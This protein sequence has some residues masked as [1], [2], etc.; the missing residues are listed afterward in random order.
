M[1]CIHLIETLKVKQQGKDC[2]HLIYR[3]EYLLPPLQLA[4]L[5]TN[6]Q[7][8][9]VFKEIKDTVDAL[10]K[11]DKTVQV[12]SSIG[13]KKLHNIAFFNHLKNSGYK[14][15]GIKEKGG[16]WLWAS[17]H[18]KDE[19]ISLLLIDIHPLGSE[20]EKVDPFLFA[21][22]YIMSNIIVWNVENDGFDAMKDIITRSLSGIRQNLEVVKSHENTKLPNITLEAPK[23]V[24]LS[25][26]SKH[27]SGLLG[28]GSN[29][30]LG[31][32]H[33][34][35]ESFL[36]KEKPNSILTSFIKVFSDPVFYRI[37]EENLDP[38]GYDKHLKE[39]EELLL[40]HFIGHKT[41]WGMDMTIGR[42]LEIFKTFVQVP[43][44]TEVIFSGRGA[45]WGG[46]R[47]GGGV[48]DPEVGN[49]MACVKQTF[50]EEIKK[51]ALRGFKK[52]IDQ[53]S[54]FKDIIKVS[55]YDTIMSVNQIISDTSE[56]ALSCTNFE[57][58]QHI[59]NYIHYCLKQA[60]GDKII[61]QL[62][63]L[64]DAQL[65][66][67]HDPAN[68]LCELGFPPVS[69]ITKKHPRS[70]V[71]ALE[72]ILTLF[73]TT[74]D[75]GAP[76]PMV[77]LTSLGASSVIKNNT[78]IKEMDNKKNT[79][80][81]QH[82]FPRF[83]QSAN[84]F[85]EFLFDESISVWIGEG[86]EDPTR[87]IAI[88]DF[89]A[90]C[91]EDFSIFFPFL[92]LI[93]SGFIMSTDCKDPNII[94]TLLGSPRNKSFIK[95]LSSESSK[96]SHF[97]E[98]YDNNMTGQHLT[99]PSVLWVSDTGNV[100]S[101]KEYDDKLCSS[102][103]ITPNSHIPSD[104]A[105]AISKGCRLSFGETFT[106]HF[107]L[108][109][110]NHY[111]TLI[112]KSIENIF[113]EKFVLQSLLPDD[114][115]KELDRII[116]I[117]K[118]HNVIKGVT[119]EGVINENHKIS[120]EK[121]YRSLTKYLDK[122]EFVLKEIAHPILSQIIY[123]LAQKSHKETHEQN[124][125]MALDICTQELKEIY[126]KSKKEFLIFEDLDNIKGLESFFERLKQCVERLEV[127]ADIKGCFET[128]IIWEKS[129]NDFLLDQVILN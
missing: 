4:T 121:I 115:D 11:I 127:P 77:V 112:N 61:E 73:H 116:G 25:H 21:L 9:P 84:L 63:N 23:L 67:K 38:K 104:F 33:S 125:K 29:I 65:T 94:N 76:I 85:F 124:K 72:K 53:K 102:G 54:F 86:T 82:L 97:I 128:N 57:Y 60:L 7:G 55:Y 16:I 80:T 20:N 42:I 95:N 48:P 6:Y 56:E 93:S 98:W 52:V 24:C 66:R 129:K 106:S 13:T 88:I 103:C 109:L 26:N 40:L 68:R 69:L 110:L 71:E 8:I 119:K 30:P 114:C 75:S 17:N 90:S 120:L 117:Y 49:R 28:L 1:L 83:L 35:F 113:D 45:N 74:R 41:F 32:N 18:P 39:F 3:L 34:Q 108:R 31:R 81:R 47:V 99:R 36:S 43:A 5:T 59:R 122:R 27:S 58:K 37:P 10:Q 107:F 19:K 14:L 100:G 70:V 46:R 101:P 64:S 15:D 96:S 89:Q 78:V 62:Q 92:Y 2:N 51:D 111:T 22:A 50:D 126:D 44:G 87:C 12:I 123:Y 91:S 79:A 118:R 105:E